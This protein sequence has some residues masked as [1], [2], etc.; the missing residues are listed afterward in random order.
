MYESVSLSAAPTTVFVACLWEFVAPRFNKEEVR[1]RG[2]VA[3]GPK[4]CFAMQKALTRVRPHEGVTK[5]SWRE[6][7]W[8]ESNPRPHKETIRFLHAYLGLHFRAAAR[9]KPPTATLSSK[10][11]SDHQG[12][13]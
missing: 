6:W 4:G 9:P 7:S 12:L 3:L 5:W 8:R 1:A 10:I 2:G 11:S 13:T